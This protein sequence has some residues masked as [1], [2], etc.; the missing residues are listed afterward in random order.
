VWGRRRREILS[1]NGPVLNS[2][3]VRHKKTACSATWEGT[4]CQKGVILTKVV[5]MLNKRIHPLGE[6][7]G[8]RRAENMFSL[9]R[10][11]SHCLRRMGWPKKWPMVYK[12]TG[13]TS[14]NRKK[15]SRIRDGTGL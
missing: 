7:R 9:G 2:S 1:K 10:E 15:K 8:Y 14:F 4:P 5:L 6:R 3:V 11:P 13:C 12:N